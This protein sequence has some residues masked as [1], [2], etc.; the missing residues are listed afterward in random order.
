MLRANPHENRIALAEL[1]KNPST[2]NEPDHRRGERIQE[3]RRERH[4][5]QKEWDEIR[6]NK[7]DKRKKGRYRGEERRGG[8]RGGEEKEDKK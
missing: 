6:C 8:E 5:I 3:S 4:E 2:S 7:P 1:P